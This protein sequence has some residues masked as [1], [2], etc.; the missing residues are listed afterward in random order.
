MFMGQYNHSVDAKGRLIVPVKFREQLGEDF[1]VT[2]GLDGCL[3]VYPNEEWISIESHFR[4][5]PLTTKDARKFS[6]FFFAGAAQCEVDKQGRILI[7]AVLREFAQLKKDVVLVGVLN[8]IEIWSIARWED[9][10][11]YDDMDEIAEHMAQLGLSI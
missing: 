7:P 9:E 11:T 2:K 5:M 6:R 10:N 3:F 8:R 4:E 1:V